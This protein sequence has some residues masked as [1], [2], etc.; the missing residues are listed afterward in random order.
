MSNADRYYLGDEETLLADDTAKEKLISR[1][2]Q[3]LNL[4]NVSLLVGNGASVPLGAPRIGNVRGLIPELSRTPYA[5]L[6]SVQQSSALGA[7]DM[8]LPDGSP[9]VGVEP[10]LGTLS[11]FL[12]DLETLPNT[13]EFTVNRALLTGVSIQS[14]ERLLKKWLYGKCSEVNLS[15]R[16]D[17]LRDHG[18]LLRRF[19]LRPTSLPRLK[20]FTVN[21]DSVLERALD[22]L[23]VFYFDGFIGT[24]RRS[25]RTESYNYDLYFPGDTAEGK[26]SRVDRV[27]QFYKMHGSLNWRRNKEGYRL[28]VIMEDSLPNDSEFGEVMIYPSPLKVTEMNGYP[29]SEM[30]RH[31][32][33]SIHQPQ[34]VLFTIGYSFSDDHVNRL[35]Y[36]ALRI[37]S[38]VLVIV[39]PTVYEPTSGSE[40][41]PEHEIWRLINKVKSKRVLVITGAQAAASGSGYATGAGILKGFANDLMPD[42]TEMAIESKVKEEADRAVGGTEA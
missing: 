9:L 42:I 6:D 3:Y 7:L 24:V 13:T 37:P 15:A 32:A 25:L 27:V 1:L 16:G 35:I 14:L 33:A 22:E 28:D 19:L 12:A 30:F 5:L 10:L 2:R 41:G 23:G 8:L 26:V 34:S 39:I 36:Q 31:F 17:V 21:Y 11:H 38:F 4:R 20:L 18:E 29:Y 40:P